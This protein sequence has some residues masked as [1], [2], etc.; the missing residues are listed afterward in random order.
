MGL[1]PYNPY[2]FVPFPTQVPRAPLRATGGHDR[3]G[4]RGLFS[5]KLVC[6]L[7]LLTPV[8]VIARDG[9]KP[10]KL[11]ASSL[12]GMLRAVAEIAGRGCGSSIGKDGLDWVDKKSSEE[13]RTSGARFPNATEHVSCCEYGGNPA[14]LARF[15][16]EKGSR[17]LDWSKM[18]L[19]SPCA[20]FGFAH[21]QAC[22][23]GRIRGSDGI[24]LRGE[25][26][27]PQLPEGDTLRMDSPHPHH[28]SHYFQPPWHWPVEG[29]YEYEGGVMLGRK[30]YRNSRQQR[31]L[32]V[33][34]LWE[35]PGPPG[36]S[37]VFQFDVRYQNLTPSELGLLLFVLDLKRGASRLAH[38]YGYGKPAGYGS[39]WISPPVVVVETPNRYRSYD[40][41]PTARLQETPDQIKDRF[42]RERPA[43]DTDWQAFERW[44]AGPPLDPRFR[45]PTRE[46]MREERLKEDS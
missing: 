30:V 11:P 6:Q 41:P 21:K 38:R 25:F 4:A 46:E 16:N 32:D 10:T 2:Q 24:L 1:P 12:R 33:A 28:L 31:R 15:E 27:L 26:R 44:L 42:F 18:V 36:Q 20:M 8:L 39:V 14:I 29:S 43:A 22:W 13:F 19:C 37:A 9:Q 45:Y 35:A 5:G 7:N 40:A 23:R 34:N 3:E 17:S